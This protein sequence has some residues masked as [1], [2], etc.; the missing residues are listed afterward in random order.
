VTI[1]E[2]ENSSSKKENQKKRRKT[3]SERVTKRQTQKN[4]NPFVDK[5]LRTEERNTNDN[6]EDLED[7][8][9]VRKKD[10]LFL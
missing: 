4:R 5:Y 7:F 3:K 9:V 8:I 1:E 10:L 2:S 6:Y